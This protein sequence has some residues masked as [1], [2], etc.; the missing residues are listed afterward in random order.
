MHCSNW[1]QLMLPL[2]LQLLLL[3]L[4]LVKSLFLLLLHQSHQ[5]QR[6]QQQFQA[7]PTDQMAPTLH[8]SHELE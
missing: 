7:V 3:L 2:L 1:Q 4:L 6:L 5:L 8:A